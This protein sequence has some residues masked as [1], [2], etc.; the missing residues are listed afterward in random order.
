MIHPGTCL[1]YIDEHIGY[2]VFAT[3]FIP[4]GTITYV[5][6]KLELEISPEVFYSYPLEL[7]AV[8]EKYSYID[9]KGIRIVSWDFAKYINHCC[10]CNS[11]STGY[12][13][14]IAIRDIYPGEEITDEYGMF[15]IENEMYLSCKYADCRKKVSALDIDL[16]ASDWDEKVKAVLSK[17]FEL[18]QP[19]LP[20]LEE[21][22]LQKLNHFMQVPEA[23]ESVAKLKVTHP[24][25]NLDFQ[26][27]GN[28]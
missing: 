26:Q 14:E 23:Y 17:I 25:V 27:N 21:E 18:H 13:F 1:R 8:V 16:Y 10:N 9:E 11:M 19:L 12:G 6:D 5:K 4:A 7:R 24:L 20:L 22:V 2:G 28:L 15:N 3:E